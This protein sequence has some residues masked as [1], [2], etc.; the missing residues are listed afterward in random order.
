MHDKIKYFNFFLFILFSLKLIFLDNL[1][2]RYDFIK[3]YFIKN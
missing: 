1:K 3:I 2:K